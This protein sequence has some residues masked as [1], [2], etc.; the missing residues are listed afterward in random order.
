VA[1]ALH[2]L[3]FAEAHVADVAAIEADVHVSPWSEASIRR[4]LTNPDGVFLVGIEGAEVAGYASAWVVVDEAHVVNVG[5]REASR[6]RGYARSLLAKLLDRCHERGATCATLEVRASNAA[7][8][9]LYRGLG[10]VE[11]GL[12]KR[13]YPGGEDAVIMWLHDLEP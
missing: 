9:A 11:C 8:L 5:V 10:F 6:R 7:A 1:K 4:E 2:I 12:R 13:Y 3:P